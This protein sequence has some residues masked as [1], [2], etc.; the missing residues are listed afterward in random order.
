[1]KF[2]T[3][4]FASKCAETSLTIKKNDSILYDPDVKKAY[5]KDSS[6]YKQFNDSGEDNIQ[7]PGEQYFDN[8]CQ[9][10]NI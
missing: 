10:N 3:A 1:M 8:F 6:K 5:C 9:R 7:D 4:K 2:I